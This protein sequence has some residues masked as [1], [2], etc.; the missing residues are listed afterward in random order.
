MKKIFTLLFIST[1]FSIRALSIGGCA[2]TAQADA[3]FPLQITFTYTGWPGPATYSWDFGDNIGT[4]TMQNPVYTYSSPGVYNVRLLLVDTNGIQ[5][6]QSLVISVGSATYCNFMYSPTGPAPS[7]VSFMST[8]T[9]PV[10]GYQ[11]DF[12]DGSPIDSSANTSHTYTSN[13][14]YYACLTT[15]D[16]FGLSCNICMAV[17]LSSS[18][19]A[20]FQYTSTGLTTYFIDNTYNSNGTPL[21]YLWE[22]GDGIS[23]TLRYPTHT[24]NFPGN[25]ISTLIVN[26]G[27]GCSDTVSKMIFVDSITP[28]FCNASFIFTEIQPYNI[29][30]VNASSGTALSWLWDFGDGSSSTLEFPS[31]TYTNTGSYIIC[32]TVND[33][34]GCNST[35]CDTLNV[36]SLGHITARGIT[37]F[38]VT[39]LSPE[40]LVL[41]TD[42]ILNQGISIYPNPVNDR[43]IVDVIDQGERQFNLYSFNGSLCR[44]GKLNK[45]RN[46]FDVSSYK[47]GLY[48]LEVISA[49]GKKIWKISVN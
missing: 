35:F 32:L 12:G 15:L 37:G 3:V 5:C 29:D 4:S 42:D 11:W 34:I 33:S 45:G 2:F 18:C 43:F 24:Y 49:S 44:S 30:I 23:G 22:F 27:F 38:T 20:D 28:V 6:N 16:T 10:V 19:N 21:Q 31:H 46:T 1:I 9:G 8:S 39:V 14:T 26:D 17:T 47:T 48:L 41:S 13:G 7:T 40:D 25:Y 36:D